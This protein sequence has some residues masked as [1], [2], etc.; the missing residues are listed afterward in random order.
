LIQLSKLSYI[1]TKKRLEIIKKLHKENPTV[2]THQELL[3]AERYYAESKRKYF[4]LTKCS[5]KCTKYCKT[6][7]T[8]NGII[9]NKKQKKIFLKKKQIKRKNLINKKRRLHIAKKVYKKHPSPATKK[10]LIHAKRLVKHA[11]KNFK[12][13]NGKRKK[14]HLK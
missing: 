6:V 8:K 5:K 11:R 7:C 1:D 4:K 2:K 3:K 12:K 13:Y 14:K 9:I 10:S